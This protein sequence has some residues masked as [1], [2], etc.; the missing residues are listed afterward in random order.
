MRDY[1]SFS[2]WNNYQR[3]EAAALARDK[4]ELQFEASE[5]MIVSKYI[6]AKLIGSEEEVEKLFEEHPEIINSRTKEPK[7]AY[8]RAEKAVEEAKEDS[9][10]MAHLKGDKQIKLEGVIDGVKIMG[11]ADNI[12]DNRFI[13]DLKAMANLNRA[14][15][16]ENRRKV[17]FVEDRNY[18][19]QGYLYTEMY[20]QQTGLEV[21]YYLAV[22]TKQDP[23]KRVIVTFDDE[24]MAVAEEKFKHGL[25]AI[26]A[27]RGGKLDPEFCGQCDYCNENQPTMRLDSRVVGMNRFELKQYYEYLEKEG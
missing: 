13:S 9:T 22:M 25:R 26:K 20:R 16:D 5:A 6:E 4:G 14:W 11:Y 2:T 24:A 23:S 18:A 1:V 3:C 19:I 7:V 8:L 12:N 21:P 27:I 17:S 15:N 10:F